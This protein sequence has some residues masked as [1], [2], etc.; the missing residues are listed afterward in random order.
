ME[1]EEHHDAA[2]TG[3]WGQPQEGCNIDDPQHGGA[4]LEAPLAQVQGAYQA[5]LDRLVQTCTE[6]AMRAMPLS[7]L[8]AV[9]DENRVWL[10][11]EEYNPHAD[12]MQ[13]K[14]MYEVRQLDFRDA[15]PELLLF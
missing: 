5:E 2:F 13:K 10:E 6:P 7:K 11:T 15:L 12:R 1:E 3:D 14:T 4:F 9:R 8:V